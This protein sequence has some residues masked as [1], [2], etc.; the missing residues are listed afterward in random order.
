MRK[1]LPVTQREYP[2]PGGRTLVSTTDLQG[3]ITYCNPA[4]IE[5]SGYTKEELIGQPH[6]LIRHPDMPSEA[7]RDMWSTIAGGQPWMAAVKN[8]R[9]DGD[10]YWVQANVTPLMAGGQPIG[11]LSVR[12]EAART[13]IEGADRLYAVMREEQAAGRRITVLHRGDV[14]RQDLV[15]RTTRLLTPG[16]VVQLASG[17]TLAAL[18]SAVAARLL[19]ATP[20]GT[21]GIAVT[22]L[23]STALGA[24]WMHRRHLAPLEGLLVSANGMAA[25]DLTQTLHVGSA[26]VM[27]RFQ[28]ALNQL[29]VNLRTIV[30][31]ARCEVDGL[32]G[33]AQEMAQG[34]HDLSQR[35]EA[36]AASL[37]E[38]ASSMEE[39]TGTVR[40]SADA[41]RS[42]ATFAA[43]VTGITERS[44]QAV[45]QVTETMQGI[46]ESS[47]RIRDIIQVIDGIA[48]QTNILAL[49]AAVEAARAGEQGR[50]FAVVAAEVRSLAQR[51]ST[52]AREV[53]Q[54]IE[55][56][57]EKVDAGA[58]QTDV[59]RGTMG[60]ALAAVQ[61]M[62]SLVGEIDTGA[63]EQLTG[64]SQVN[65]AV[66]HMDGLTQQNAALVEQLAAAATSVRT[67]AEAVAEA[68]R[69]FRVAA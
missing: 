54:L 33:T 6:N 10:H 4:F 20:L 21:A 57:A 55:H 12:T 66:S 50:G 49:N 59:A 47:D 28:R 64:I 27:G 45:H 39:I 18:A 67:Q 35:T 34:N 61:R 29:N 16:P 14:R 3:R 46:R 23:A 60:E 63:S 53:K 36:Q 26:G 32:R 42:V 24:W 30:G 41:A 2:F 7:F 52:A 22:V 19:P 15:G 58:Q 5:V 40:Q 51:T 11:Y 9:K 1:N 44:A 17:F 37:E 13:Q 48:F 69:I 68:V 38:T 8:R 43:Q 31:D 56:S 25:G 65:D 62:A